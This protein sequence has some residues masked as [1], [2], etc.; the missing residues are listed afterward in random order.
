MY[1]P[2]PKNSVGLLNFLINSA[3]YPCPFTD[4][5]KQ[6]SLSPDRESAPPCNNIAYGLKFYII[7]VITG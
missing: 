4:K 6:P 7:F 1:P 2:P 5:L 3:A